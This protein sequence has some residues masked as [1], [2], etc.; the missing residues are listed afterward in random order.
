MYQVSR[1]PARSIYYACAWF[2]ASFQT[3]IVGAPRYPVYTTI[4]V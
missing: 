3:I 4:S 1:Y 2:V